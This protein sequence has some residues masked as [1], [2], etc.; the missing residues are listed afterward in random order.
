MAFTTLVLFQ[1]FNIFNARSD[2]ASAFTG[3]FSNLWLWAGVALSLA[4]HG[5][6]IYAPFLQQA[7]STV[8][9][10]ARDW[11]VCTAVASSVLWLRE[12]SKIMARAR[13]RETPRKSRRL[14]AT[15]T[16]AKN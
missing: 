1:L 13:S 2:E 5:A 7:F 16:E 6:V 14:D 12:A 11:L 9:L 4:L 10:E 8:P 15:G 3:L